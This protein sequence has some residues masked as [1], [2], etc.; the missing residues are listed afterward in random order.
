MGSLGIAYAGLG[1][2][3]KA[4]QFG[5]RAMGLYSVDMDAWGGLIRVADLA[6]IY[7]MVKEYD[8]A[9]EQLEIILSRPG[10]YSAALLN[11]D[12]KWKPLWDNPKFIR[13]IEKYSKKGVNS[14]D[15]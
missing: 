11:L 8:A 1:D 4:I 9:L 3:E 13:L 15:S 10:P 12:P 14:Y 2:K 5:K 6:W 7:V